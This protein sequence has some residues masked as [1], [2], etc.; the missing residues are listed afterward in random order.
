LGDGAAALEALLQ[1]VDLQPGDALIHANLGNARL[2][3]GQFDAAIAAHH[4]AVALAPGEAR[5]RRNLAHAL[6]AAGDASA[7][8]AQLRMA[9]QSEPED[10]ALKSEALFVSLYLAH[11]THAQRAVCAEALDFAASVAK[12]VQGGVFEHWANLAQPERPLRVG[13]VS[14]DL[15]AHPISYLLEL[16]LRAWADDSAAPV[17]VV[18]YANQRAGDST[19]DRLRA[20]CAGWRNVADLSD[21]A[22]C[23]LIRAD[24][25]DVLLDVSGHTLGNR[26]PM[27]ARRP[28]PVQVAWLGFSTTTGLNCFDAVL[29]DP[30]LAPPGDEGCFVEPVLRLPQTAFCMAWPTAGSAQSA[31]P[32]EHPHN[33]PPPPGS[34]RF[35]CFNHL[36]K[37]GP[38][39]I[40]VWAR[41]LQ[42]VPGSSLSLQAAPFQDPAVEHRVRLA[43]AAHAV[44]PDRLR[45]LPSTSREAYLQAYGEIDIALD[46][47]PY[48]GGATS[49]EALWMGVPVLTMTGATPLSRQGVSFLMNLGLPEWVAQDK[50]DYVARAVR[51]AA[52]PLLLAQLKGEL[53]QRMAASPLCNGGLMARSV[54]DALRQLWRQWCSSVGAAI[55]RSAD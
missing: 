53:R 33:M 4:E 40:A 46:P 12:A 25:V 45:L 55:P 31:L 24:G 35:G 6:R 51:M 15:R 14:A 36:A 20:L 49:L 19:S 54:H 47:F 17:Q 43:F 26:L 8:L 2:G 10:L 23:E 1:A 28:A 22:L 11:D 5:F 41:I 39:V 21:Q 52:N 32:N 42:S 16:I 13:L 7:A 29:A 30:F 38:E 27:F 37:M 18:A 50:E 48:P 3:C 34:T 44:E 9:L